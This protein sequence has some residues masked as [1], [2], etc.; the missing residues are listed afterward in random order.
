[1]PSSTGNPFE[2]IANV[3]HAIERRRLKMKH[4]HVDFAESGLSPKRAWDKI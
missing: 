3:N 2:K 1:M 4:I